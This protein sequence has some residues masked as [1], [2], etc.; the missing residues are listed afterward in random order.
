M[1]RKGNILGSKVD[2]D[3]MECLQTGCLVHR[4]QPSDVFA[5]VGVCQQIRDF[6]TNFRICKIIIVGGEQCHYDST[7][8]F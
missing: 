8:I 2:Y 5:K 6:L 3:T 4:R 1:V 7:Y